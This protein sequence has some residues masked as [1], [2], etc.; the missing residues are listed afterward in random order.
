MN[1]SLK[2]TNLRDKLIQVQVAFGSDMADYSVVLLPGDGTGPE[3]INQAKKVMDLIGEKT[4]I[5]FNYETIE[6][7]GKHFLDTGKEWEEGSFERCKN[8]DSMLLGAIG[9]PGALRENGDL[10]GGEVVLGLR[11]GLDLYANVRPIK[12][13][14]GVQHKIHGKFKSVWDYKNVDMCILRENTEGLYYGALQRSRARATG[15]EF[16]ESPPLDFP[17]LSGEIAWDPRVISE[18]GSK[19]I[20]S[21]AFEISSRRNGAPSDGKSRVTCIDK[22]NVARGCQL[23]RGIFDGIASKNPHIETNYAYIDAFTMWLIR[24]PEEFDVVVTSNM[25]GDIA[26]DLGSVLQ[27]GMGMAASGNIGDDH[28]L[29]E[30]VHGS[31]PKYAGKNIVNPIATINSLQM[32]LEWLGEKHNDSALTDIG[33]VVNQAVSEQI[34]E[35]KMITYDLGGS[36]TTSDVGDDLVKRISNLLD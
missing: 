12:L 22:S 8:A 3:V 17:G 18:N 11:S 27:G 35:G 21:K 33:S 29:F 14:N 36:S 6:C 30:P 24:N 26:T 31:S 1:C 16:F 10:A 28:A 32:M 4:S 5:G 13:F 7:G 23:F 34:Q 2:N 15:E 9:W 20:I 19:R 25:F